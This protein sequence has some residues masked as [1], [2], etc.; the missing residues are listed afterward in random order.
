MS[1]RSE[2]LLS[3]VGEDFNNRSTEDLVKLFRKYLENGIH[4]LCFSSYVEG[5]GPGSII[6]KEQIRERI[7]IIKPYARWIRT[8]SCTD[9]N[10][11]IP[12]IARENGLKVMVGAWLSDDK[13]Q[14][15]IEIEN[16]VK[17][18]N[19]GNA[20]LVAVGNEVLYRE[21]LT[22]QELL[23][24]IYRVKEQLPEASVGYVDAYYE[25]IARPVITEACDVIFTNCYP[26]WEGCHIDYSLVYI[27]NMYY[28]VL[29]A[30]KGKRIVISETGWPNIGT[31][32]ESSE[33]TKDNALRY[34][35]NTQK[36]SSEENIE[37]MYFSSFD[38]SWKV[39]SEGD[40]GAYWGIWDKDGKL[41]Y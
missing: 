33:P 4:G 19:E 26:F 17:V 18:V 11:L 1:F 36:W 34:F 29:Q 30:A 37:I 20:D 39:G 31:A 14:N 8:F 41:K 10:E 38:E 12:S 3:L 32:F 25:F 2:K 24:Y 16:L 7:R 28:S 15:E 21:E 35:I 27:K 22:E 9:G 40:V 5:Q 13:E 6:S 23:E